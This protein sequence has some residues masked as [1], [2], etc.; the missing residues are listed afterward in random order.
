M[1]VDGCHGQDSGDACEVNGKYLDQRR[2]IRA[3]FACDPL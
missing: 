2:V 3:Q 1:C